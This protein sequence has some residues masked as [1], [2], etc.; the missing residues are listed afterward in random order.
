VT[1][2]LPIRRRGKSKGVGR[3]CDVFA[4]GDRDE[5]LQLIKRH[6]AVPWRCDASDY[7]LT[8]T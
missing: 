2:S 5:D 7:Q 8:I 3:A 6:A 4:L 1:P